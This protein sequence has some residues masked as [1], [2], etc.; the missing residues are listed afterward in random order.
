MILLKTLA[1]HWFGFC[2]GILSVKAA[3]E[4][5]RN[6]QKPTISKME[7]TQNNVP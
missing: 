4:K 5:I 3:L 1:W 6:N 2:W 7:T